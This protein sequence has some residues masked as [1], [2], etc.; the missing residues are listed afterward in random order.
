[1]QFSNF[2]LEKANIA[3]S[4][5]AVHFAKLDS[6]FNFFSPIVLYCLTTAA[7][8]LHLTKSKFCYFWDTL[9]HIHTHKIFACLFVCLS[10]PLFGGVIG[11]K[12]GPKAPNPGWKVRKTGPKAPKKGPETPQQPRFC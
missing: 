10:P 6:K 9:I 5:Y 4:K 3:K 1:M 2:G 12:T 7:T 11:P 8:S